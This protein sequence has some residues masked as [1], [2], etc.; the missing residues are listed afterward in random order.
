[1]DVIREQIRRGDWGPGHRLVESDLTTELGI[2]RGPVREAFAR[3]AAE[4][5]VTVQPYRGAMVSKL[6]AEDLASL[7]D[8]REVLEGLAARLVAA[9]IDEPGVRSSIL[10][11]RR[12]MARFGDD[13]VRAE[14]FDENFLFHQSLLELSHNPH[15]LEASGRF[16]AQM[17]RYWMRALLDGKSLT[18]S[19]KEH[20]AIIDAVLD[21]NQSKAERLMRAHVC[22]SKNAVLRALDTSTQSKPTRAKGTRAGGPR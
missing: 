15:L 18:Q 14:Y 19:C 12:A 11:R 10:E 22:A 20:L 7:Y 9:R 5:L 3:L 13:I 1:M 17:Y 8:V 6:S 16:G 21:G 4:G 2:S